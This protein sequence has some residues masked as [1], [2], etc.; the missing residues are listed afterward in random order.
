MWP[1]ANVAIRTGQQSGVLVLDID[2]DAGAESVRELERRHGTLPATA[3]VVT[4]RGGQH[5]YFAH[6]GGEIRN[7][8]GALG[9]GL[10]IRAD[11]GY[12]LAPPSIGAN[13]RRYEPDERAPLAAMPQWL[14]E[15]LRRPGSAS[16]MAAAAPASEWVAIVRD[17]LPAGQ[18]NHGLARLVGHLLAHDVDARLA[19]ELAQLV[20]LRCRPPLTADE[21]NRV[22]ESIA[23]R[24][25]S[26]RK[27]GQR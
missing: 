16:G 8:A 11:G 26:K 9:A 7:S 12:V 15:R 22:V 13:G 17:G 10:D 6:P 27:R 24:E 21:V 5:I 4:P 25:L 14:K 20:A 19:R 18:R 23:G 1:E 2:G 3:T